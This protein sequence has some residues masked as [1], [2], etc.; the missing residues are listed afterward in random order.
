[1][2]AFDP[3]RTSMAWA[4]S[5]VWS[6]GPRLDVCQHNSSVAFV[7]GELTTAHCHA[8]CRSHAN[9]LCRSRRKVEHDTWRERSPIIHAYRNRA[10][11]F[12]ITNHKAGTEG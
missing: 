7:R 12:W 11:R 10:P 6:F 4:T 9:G 8:L 1:M 5:R 2:S 3:K